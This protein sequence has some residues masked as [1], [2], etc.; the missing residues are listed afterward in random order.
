ML[1]GEAQG[2]VGQRCSTF[3]VR[4]LIFS[5][6]AFVLKV[7]VDVA[8]AVCCREFGTTSEINRAGHFSVFG[9]DHRR[10][11]A[12]AVEGENPGGRGIIDDGIRLLSG[13]HFCD[14]LQR[15]QVE[16]GDRGGLPVANKSAA[17]VCRDGDSMHARG[18]FD[19][20]DNR[21]RVNIEHFDLRPVRNVEAPVGFVDREIVPTTLSRNGDFSGDG[22]FGGASGSYQKGATQN[23]KSRA[24]KAND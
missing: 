13:G 19:F 2:A 8:V 4:E 5:T 9:F 22:V 7:I 14:G 3:R 11:V 6:R 17:E 12:A 16:D 21:A 23:Q 15:F 24:D 10:A 18:V 20:A 1:E